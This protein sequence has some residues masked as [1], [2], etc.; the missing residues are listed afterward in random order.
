MV[1]LLADDNRLLLSVLATIL[2]EA[3]HEVLAADS[4]RKALEQ[5]ERKRPDAAIL[6]LYMP[7]VSGAEVAAECRTRAVPFVF[8]SAYDETEIS[9]TAVSLGARGY[10][11]KP[12]TRGA[13]LA[14]LERCA[15]AGAGG[16]LRCQ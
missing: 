4:G 13:M 7:L 14:A 6:D 2:R 3:G 11:L 1:V 10:L 5:L 15:G 9:T 16:G 8:I 12:T